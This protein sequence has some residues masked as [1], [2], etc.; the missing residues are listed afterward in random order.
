MQAPEAAAAVAVDFEP[1]T[2]TPPDQSVTSSAFEPESLG[3]VDQNGDYL[4]LDG[5]VKNVKLDIE[6]EAEIDWPTENAG[7]AFADVWKKEG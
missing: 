7:R 1:E 2:F 6:G 3:G 5:N 4:D